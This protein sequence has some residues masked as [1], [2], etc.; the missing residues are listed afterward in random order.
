M[1]RNTARATGGRHEPVVSELAGEG[2]PLILLH[3]LAGSARWWR[4]NVPALSRRF[5]VAAI[6]LPGFGSSHRDARLILHETA[7]QLLSV[8]DR[9]GFERAHVVGHSM[10]GLVAG[11]LAADHPERV[12][13]LVLVDA[14]FL[15]LDPSMIRRVTGPVAALRWTSPT[16]LPVVLADALRSGPIRMADATRQILQADWRA[17]LPGIRAPTLVVWGEHDTICPPVIGREI[18]SRVPGSRLVVIAG[19]AHCPMWERPESFDREVLA[20]L[21]EDT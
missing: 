15:S 5:R 3:G 7:G 13:R 2:P 4:H 8:M 19:A 1:G 14:G 6:D 9:L 18:R 21:D 12:D 20:F 11:G 17:K 16:L 10:G